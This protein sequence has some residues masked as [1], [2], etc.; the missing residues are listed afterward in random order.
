[1]RYIPPDQ[2]EAA[3]QAEPIARYRDVL[4]ADGV[5]DQ[6]GAEQIA[7]QAGDEVE[8]AFAAALGADLPD[9]DEAWIDVYGDRA[10]GG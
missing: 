3:R 6:Q 4:V 8:A 10:V 2:L 5:L 7:R 1:M 9:G